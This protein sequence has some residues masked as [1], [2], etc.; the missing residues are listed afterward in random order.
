MLNFASIC[1]HPPLLIPTIGKSSDLNQVEKTIKSMK[2]LANNFKKA[3]IDTVVVI[4]PHGAMLYDYFATNSSPA[5]SGSF[6][7]FGDFKTKFSF[8]NDLDFIL[9]LKEN[10]KKE[11]I[12]FQ[13]IKEQE[14]D[15]GILV[16]IYFL[17]KNIF[18]IKLVPISFSLLDIKTHFNFGKVLQEIANNVQRTKRIAIVASGDLSHRLTSD[19][20]AGYSEKGK[21]FDEKLVELLQKKDVNSIL[22]M[23]KNFVEQAGECGYRSIIIL[24]GA[25]DGLDWEPEILS[26]EGPFGVGY[27]VANFKI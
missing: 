17:A 16:P 3:E 25:L 2:V 18:G 5:L 10:C 13:E 7:Y 27:L 22:N 21:E 26:Y 9:K 15:H 1:P 24:L 19:A 4:T 6:S 20:P 14:L 11:K 8:E 23:D 12:P